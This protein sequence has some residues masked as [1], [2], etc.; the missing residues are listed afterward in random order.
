M[1]DHSTQPPSRKEL[2][3]RA[4]KILA[5]DRKRNSE[6]ARNSEASDIDLLSERDRLRKEARRGKL[7]IKNLDVFPETRRPITA[8]TAENKLLAKE[9]SRSLEVATR[10]LLN[11]FSKE[12]HEFLYLMSVTQGITDI[13][14]NFS[15]SCLVCLP[16]Q[17]KVHL[18]LSASE[19]TTLKRRIKYKVK[20][21]IKQEGSFDQI[22]ETL[23]KECKDGT[24][25]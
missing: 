20:K 18:R 15:I 23:A 1:S 21:L 3:N 24:A 17:K 4:T 16:N 25:N 19:V 9:R 11:L 22:L 8:D 13:R 12:P 14:S 7:L 10:R 5:A 2:E 6:S